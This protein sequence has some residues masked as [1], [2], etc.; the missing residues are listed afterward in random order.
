MEG[1]PGGRSEKTADTGCYAG[2][3]LWPSSAPSFLCGVVWEPWFVHEGEY[4]G[5]GLALAGKDHSV[6]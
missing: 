2:D 6:S 1:A 4:A 5:A 3:Q